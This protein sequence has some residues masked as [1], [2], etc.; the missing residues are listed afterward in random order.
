MVA[1]VVVRRLDDGHKQYGAPAPN[2]LTQLM[3]AAV[4]EPCLY[5]GAVS[6]VKKKKSTNSHKQGERR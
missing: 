3:S 4:L 6:N 2:L 1:A 5:V